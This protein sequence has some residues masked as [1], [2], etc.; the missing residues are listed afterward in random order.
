MWEHVT[1]LEILIAALAGLQAG[2]FYAW[3][4]RLGTHF[5][6]SALLSAN[7]FTAII[8][9]SAIVNKEEWEE[10][11]GIWVLWLTFQLG[12]TS[13]YKLRKWWSRR[14]RNAH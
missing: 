8:V 11:V 4:Q 2:A 9:A 10:W 3:S 6:H 1:L 13:G 12:V 5:F 7:F 14:S